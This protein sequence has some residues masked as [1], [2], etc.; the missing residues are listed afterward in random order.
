[1]VYIFQRIYQGQNTKGTKLTAY[2]LRLHNWFFGQQSFHQVRFVLHKQ[3][4]VYC[5][6]SPYPVV[7]NTFFDKL[8]KEET[9]R[10]LGFFEEFVLQ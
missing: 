6:F 10:N 2:L 9:C 5:N 4:C 8:P 7:S 3:N 1:M